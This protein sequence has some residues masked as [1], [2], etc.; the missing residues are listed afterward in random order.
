MLTSDSFQLIY[1]KE[2]HQA[3]LSFHSAVIFLLGS[4]RPFSYLGK[5]VLLKPAQGAYATKQIHYCYMKGLI[6]KKKAR[7][8][9][10]ECHSQNRSPSQTPRERGNRQI[11]T[12]TDR[13]NVRKALR[14]ALSSPSEVIAMLKGLRNTRTE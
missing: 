8:K 3:L 7:K 6:E 1:V 9:S 13:T 5:R 10:R 4:L 14:L 2:S 12:S 11:Q